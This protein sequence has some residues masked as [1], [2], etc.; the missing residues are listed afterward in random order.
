MLL[1]TFT[2]LKGKKVSSIGPTNDTSYF[3][4]FTKPLWTW[5]V[6][7]LQTSVQQNTLISS[8]FLSCFCNSN[9]QYGCAWSLMWAESVPLAGVLDKWKSKHDIMNC[10]HCANKA[11]HRKYPCKDMWNVRSQP[12]LNDCK[13][14][15]WLGSSMQSCWHAHVKWIIVVLKTTFPKTFVSHLASNRV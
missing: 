10:C 12:L 11:I 6:L 8:L 13:A 9:N 14:F 2:L 4:L 7:N 3:T 15:C 5:H 1:V